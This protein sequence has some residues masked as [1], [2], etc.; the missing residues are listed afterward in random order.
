MSF[1]ASTLSSG[2]LLRERL[3]RNWLRGLRNVPRVQSM[4]L[5]LLGKTLCALELVRELP[6]LICV[7]LV[8]PLGRRGRT[9][10]KP[11]PPAPA[12]GAR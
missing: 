3:R 7:A 8:A 9:W 11:C 5:Y 2:E 10:K 1:C 6:G 12:L 4:L